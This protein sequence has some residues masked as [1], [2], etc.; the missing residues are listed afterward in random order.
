MRGSIEKVMENVVY[1]HS[2]V[3]GY[4]VNVGILRAGEVDFVATKG[5]KTIYVQVTYLLVSEET[6]K[7]EFRNLVG[8]RDNYPKYV[9]SMDPVRGGLNEYPGINHVHLREFLKM[10]L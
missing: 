3:Q 9:V 8:I 4:N 5:D 10:E 7:R 1:L 6:V 2:L